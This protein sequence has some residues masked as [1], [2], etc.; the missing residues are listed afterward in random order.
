M[1]LRT[2][3]FGLLFVT[4]CVDSGDPVTA[5]GKSVYSPSVETL[6]L[7]DKG[8]GFVIPGPPGPCDPYVAS[9]TVTV[10]TQ[11]LAWSRCVI[12]G[13]TTAPRSGARPLTTDEWASLQPTLRALVIV[14][15]NDCGADKPVLELSVTTASSSQA[16]GDAFYGCHIHDRPVIDSNAL[17]AAEDALAALA[18][19]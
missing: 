2:F 13:N 10:D 4:A 5:V 15:N 6:V 19:K 12:T 11:H 1:Q 7:D 8:G 9:Y 16:Y 14:S 18:T 17:D 3:A